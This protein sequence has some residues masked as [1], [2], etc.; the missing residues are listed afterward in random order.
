M[1]EAGPG[2]RRR[3]TA[4]TTPRHHRGHDGRR[5]PRHEEPRQQRQEG[6]R[7]RRPRTTRPA[8]APA[9]RARRGRCPAPRG[10]GPRGRS[11]GRPSSPRPAGG[12][13][14]STPGPGR[15]GPAPP[16]RRGGCARSSMRSRASSRSSSSCL[17]LHRVVL[18]AAIETAP[19]IRPA[20]PA[21]RTTAGAGSAP[22]TPRMRPTLR[23]QP[24]AHAEHGGPGRHHPGRRGG[25]ARLDR[26]SPVR[27]RRRIGH[28]GPAR[29]LSGSC[30]SPLRP[31]PR[32][33]RRA[34]R[35]RAALPRRPGVG[36]PLR[37]APR[38]GGD[39]QPARRPCAPGW[40]PSCRSP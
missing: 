29:S 27:R 40:P 28:G 16:S 2:P 31:R 11:R 19:T 20:R 38:P 8:P 32:R 15:A 25:G 34:A 21:S 39:D 13:V 26:A 24:V 37:P 1:R 7:A 35:R 18:A 23:D 5:C 10:R 33:A 14:G 17:D 4:A 3:T 12:P 9:S 6:P 30:P 22:A 36:R